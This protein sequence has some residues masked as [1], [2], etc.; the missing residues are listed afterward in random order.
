MEVVVYMDKITF[1]E[2]EA[3]MSQDIISDNTSIEAEF[4]IDGLSIYDEACLGKKNHN[5]TNTILYWFGLVPDGS[6]AY[7][8]NSFEEFINANVLSGRSLKE[9]WDS[10]S[11]LYINTYKNI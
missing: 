5:D 8:F 9:L 1:F 4:R 11:F 6:Q 2:F 3:I 7:T 10:V